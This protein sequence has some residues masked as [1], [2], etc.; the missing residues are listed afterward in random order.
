M[1]CMRSFGVALLLDRGD[2]SSQQFDHANVYMVHGGRILILFS[3]LYYAPS[4][5]W[6]KTY[7]QLLLVHNPSYWEI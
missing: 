1:S 7:F 4:L 6:M 2:N 3:E 5:T